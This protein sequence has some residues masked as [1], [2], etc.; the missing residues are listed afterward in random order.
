MAQQTFTASQVLTATQMNTLQTNDYNW[1]TNAQ[2]ASYTLVATDKGKIVTMNNASATTITVNTSLFS[3]GDTLKIQN[4]GAGT[5]VVTAGTATVTSLGSL[6]IPQWG[7]GTLYFTSASASIWYPNGASSGLTLVSTGS[8]SNQ[9]TVSLPNSTFTSTYQ[10]YLIFYQVQALSSNMTMRM[11]ASGTDNTGTNYIAASSGYQSQGSVIQIANNSANA[12]GIGYG[13]DSL[14]GSMGYVIQMFR[15]QQAQ[16]TNFLYQSTSSS[17]AFGAQ[18]GLQGG[19]VFNGTT[20]FDSLSIISSVA[21]S[22]TGTYRVYGLA[23]A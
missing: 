21:S 14:S 17:S 20:Q 5:C 6:S 16:Y 3:A 4:I 9:T 11:R 15:P 23:D 13:F 10:N 8:F 1:A 2:T 19:G 18:G 7:G 12:W 22:Q